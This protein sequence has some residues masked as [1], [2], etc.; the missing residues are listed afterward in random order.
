MEPREQ[1]NAE[2]EKALAEFAEQKSE[3][4]AFMLLTKSG[5]RGISV[6]LGDPRDMRNLLRKTMQVEPGIKKIVDC[7][8]NH[9]HDE[10]EDFFEMLTEALRDFLKERRGEEKKED[11]KPETAN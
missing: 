1:M 10:S 6:V 8:L 9:N 3:C 4:T 7:A 2:I 11:P 5:K